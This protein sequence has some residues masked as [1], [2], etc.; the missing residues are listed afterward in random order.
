MLIDGLFAG[1]F[2]AIGIQCARCAAVTTTEG[3]PDGG[4]PPRSAI[5]ADAVGRSHGW[6][7]MTVPPGYSVV[8]QAEM[9]RLQALFQPA[10]PDNTYHRVR[11]PAGRGRRG[12]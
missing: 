5:V 10:T 4:L 11:C 2:L 3:L 9:E 8:G 1:A 12:V 7:A 6:T